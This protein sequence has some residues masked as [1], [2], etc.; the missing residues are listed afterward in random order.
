MA[1]DPVKS[2]LDVDYVVSF[3]I[4]PKGRTDTYLC[5]L[6]LTTQ[7]KDGS[8]SQFKQL[9]R[10]LAG[11]GLTTE[12]RTGDETSLLVFIKA[13]DEQVLSNV[14]YRSRMKDW[15]YGIRQVQPVQDTVS[16]LTNEPLTD[17]ERH[18]HIYQMITALP[19]DGGAGVTPNSGEWKRVEAVFPLHDHARNKKW[20]SEFS[21]KTFLSPE[22]LDDIKDAVGEQ[23][24][25]SRQS[26]Q[27]NL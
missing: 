22:D 3:R 14:V 15:L 1:K 12:V 26:P 5:P 17:A 11:V 7:D 9:I 24:G 19:E 25:H 21:R 23:V 8:V 20:L 27:D 16:A 6:S 10:A 4:D 2:N 18:R 13:A